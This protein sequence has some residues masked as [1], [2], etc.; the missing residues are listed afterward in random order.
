MNGKASYE[1]DYNDNFEVITANKSCIQHHVDLI[2]E[3]VRSIEGN[4]SPDDAWNF[5][6]PQ[7]VLSLKQG[8]YEIDEA[9]FIQQPDDNLPDDNH[10]VQNPSVSKKGPSLAVESLPT[11]RSDEQYRRH[12]QSLNF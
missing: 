10:S 7:N 12:I 5:L 1:E 3:A 4:G 8:R 9:H 11:I 2:E 6:A